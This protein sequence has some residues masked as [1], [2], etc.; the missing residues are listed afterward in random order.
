MSTSKRKGKIGVHQEQI[1]NRGFGENNR[2]TAQWDENF[3]IKFQK[4][5]SKNAIA[6]NLS[7]RIQ[8][9]IEKKKHVQKWRKKGT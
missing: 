1:E 9:C 6:R 7:E 2:T 8:L 3:M 4:S 5:N